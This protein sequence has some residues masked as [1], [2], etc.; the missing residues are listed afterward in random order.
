MAYQERHIT[1]DERG[2]W[3]YRAA[4]G[5]ATLSDEAVHLATGMVTAGY[6]SVVATL[7][8]IGD[9]E[10]PLVARVFYDR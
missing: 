6:Q 5:D 10:A 2:T 4:P 7:W 8:S 9:D 1:D 3:M